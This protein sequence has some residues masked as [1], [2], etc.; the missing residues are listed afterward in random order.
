MQWRYTKI[1]DAQTYNKNTREAE[2]HMAPMMSILFWGYEWCPAH[3][4]FWCSIIANENDNVY[5]LVSI[6]ARKQ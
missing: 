3:A 5:P 6:V 2:M 1:I 4:P